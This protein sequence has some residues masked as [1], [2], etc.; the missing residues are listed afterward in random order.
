[1]TERAFY[2]PN[3]SE[4]RFFCFPHS[5]GNFVQP[6]NHNV[7]RPDGVRDYSLHYV[8]SGSGFIE[9][10]GETFQLREG[11]VFWHIPDDRMRYYRSEE[12]PWNIF[13]MQ[14]Y[15]STL[16]AFITENG[17]HQ[18]GIWNLKDGSLLEGTFVSL[19]DEIEHHNFLRPARI[20]ALTYSVLIEFLS[21]STPFSPYRGVDNAQKMRALLPEM[22]RQAHLPFI[23]EDWAAAAGYTPNYFCSLFKKVTRMTPV[24]YIT[25]CRIQISKHLLVSHPIIPIKEVAERAGYPGFSYFNKKFMESEGVTPGEFRRNHTALDR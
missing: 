3:F 14:L 5:V 9:L 4:F 22:Q 18:S 23:L 6:T 19:L 2:L 20:S 10:G 15:G 24:S 1:M 17:Y 25:K 16:P 13:W 7:N 12:D 8:A 21:N 11:D